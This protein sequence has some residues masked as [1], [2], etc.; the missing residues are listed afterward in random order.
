M[1]CGRD[2]EEGTISLSGAHENTKRFA[3]ARALYEYLASSGNEAALASRAVTNRQAVNRAFA[4]EL[5]APAE[6]VRRELFGSAKS[7]THTR[8]VGEEDISELADH[9]GV[10]TI[11]I[12]RQIENHGLA[13]MTVAR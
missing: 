5:L 7:D 9:F 3:Y 10:S 1:V 12:E 2:A 8:T 4:A 13:Q 11:V 6:G